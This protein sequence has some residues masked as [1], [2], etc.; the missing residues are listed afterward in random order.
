MVSL[1]RVASSHRP[2]SQR[3]EPGALEIVAIEKVVRVERN[4]TAIG[5]HDVDAALFHGPQIE[6]MRVDELDDQKPKDVAVA[7]VSLYPWQ[8]AR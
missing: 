7:D 5:M 2:R 3:L 6:G 1:A 8:A 4:Q